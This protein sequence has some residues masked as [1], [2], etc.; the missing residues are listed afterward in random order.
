V[1]E[2]SDTSRPEH[3]FAAAGSGTLAR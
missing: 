1:S 3:R 2:P